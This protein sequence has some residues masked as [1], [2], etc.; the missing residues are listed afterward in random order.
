MLAHLEGG[1]LQRARRPLLCISLEASRHGPGARLGGGPVVRL[2]DRQGPFAPD[3]SRRL[4]AI[5]TRLL[6]GRY[7]RRLM[8]GGSCEAS[9][10]LAHGLPTAGLALPLG[11]YH[12]QNLDGGQ[13]ASRPG[14]PAPEFVDP[15][16]TGTRVRRSTRHRRLADAVPGPRGQ[17]LAERPLGAG[18]GAPQAT[19][20]RRTPSARQA[21]NSAL[22]Q[23]SSSRKAHNSV[24]ITSSEGSR[25]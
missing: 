19:P 22:G 18:P 9:A 17:S 11:N 20:A 12:N 24:Q 15:G 4:D 6:Q 3:G 13:D 10:M 7:Q 25:L 16:W 5:A 14:G 8:D 21:L 1:W 23:S 2:G